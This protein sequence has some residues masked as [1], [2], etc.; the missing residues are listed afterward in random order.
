[1]SMLIKEHWTKIKACPECKSRKVVVAKYPDGKKFLE[2][3]GCWGIKRNL[4][5]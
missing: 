2:C 4:L 1:M 3:E 5:Y